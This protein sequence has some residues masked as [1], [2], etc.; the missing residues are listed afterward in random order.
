MPCKLVGSTPTQ[1]R[2]C[3]SQPLAR[4]FVAPKG[5]LL[6]ICFRGEQEKICQIPHT[7]WKTFKNFDETAEMRGRIELDRRPFIKLT[8]YI[9]AIC[10]TRAVSASGLEITREQGSEIYTGAKTIFDNQNHHNENELLL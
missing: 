2:T 7:K 8:T 6:V 10:F 1:L 3:R 5:V 4:S 9:D